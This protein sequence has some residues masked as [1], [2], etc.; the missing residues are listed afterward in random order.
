MLKKIICFIFNSRKIFDKVTA[1]TRRLKGNINGNADIIKALNKIEN[2]DEFFAKL[3]RINKQVNQNKVRISLTPDAN[4]LVNN[5]YSA[6]LSKL[7]ELGKDG[8]NE[9]FS[10]FG[11]AKV[12]TKNA[13]TRVYRSTKSTIFSSAKADSLSSINKEEFIKITT[14]LLT[15]S[16]SDKEFIAEVLSNIIKDIHDGFLL[17]CAEVVSEL[18]PKD[19]KFIKDIWPNF[20]IHLVLFVFNYLK[21]LIPDNESDSAFVALMKTWIRNGKI[22]KKA[23]LMIKTKFLE[24]VKEVKNSYY[25]DPQRYEDFRNFRSSNKQFSQLRAGHTIQLGNHEILVK[26]ATIE[27]FETRLEKY[28]QL[29]CDLLTALIFKIISILTPANAKKMLM[30]NPDE[31]LIMRVSQCLFRISKIDE[32]II[33][34]GGSGVDVTNA[35]IATL[36][37][38]LTVVWCS[39]Q[40]IRRHSTCTSCKGLK[41]AD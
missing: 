36:L 23:I 20:E 25:D 34:L 2:K 28:D 35:D 9:L 41:Y 1:E 29:Q 14:F 4:T 31:D 32:L 22:D 40:R 3:G 27:M 18:V 10:K 6:S 37:K 21:K 12:D 11:P 19:L 24:K 26:S 15:L 17:L 39:E 33:L 38:D 13:P 30:T 5:E 8:R 7:Y 16:K